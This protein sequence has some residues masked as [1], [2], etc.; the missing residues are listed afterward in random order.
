[1]FGAGRARGIDGTLRLI[2]FLVRGFRTGD[3]NEDDGKPRATG[4]PRGETHKDLSIDESCC[5]A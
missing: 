2:H 4:D 3:R 1:L 5:A